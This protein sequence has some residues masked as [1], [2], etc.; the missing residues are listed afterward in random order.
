M[1]LLG[2]TRELKIVMDNWNEV[3]DNWTRKLDYPLYEMNYICGIREIFKDAISQSEWEKKR[4]NR[5]FMDVKRNVFTFFGKRGT[6]KTT[7]MNEFCEILSKLEYDNEKRR[8]LAQSLEK[9]EQSILENKKFKFHVLKPI[10]ASLLEDKENLFELIMANIYLEFQNKMEQSSNYHHEEDYQKDKTSKIMRLFS[11]IFKSYRLINGHRDEDE[12]GN[13]IV[14]KMQLLRGSKHLEE[15]VIGLIEELFKISNDKCDYEYIVIPI[16]DLDLNVKHGYEMLEQLQKYFSYYKIVVLIAIDYEQM[17]LVCEEHF[18]REMQKTTDAYK[19][20]GREHARE[21]AN[22]YMTKIFQFSQRMYMPDMRRLSRKC[23]IIVEGYKRLKV[24]NFIMNKVAQSMFI[25]Y[26]ACGNQSHFSE[27]D[28]VR[29]LVSYNDFLETLNDI[30]YDKLTKCEKLLK[31]GVL[32]RDEANKINRDILEQYD[33]NHERFNLDINVRMAQSIML[34]YQ[35][36]AFDLLNTQPI[37]RRAQLFTC[38]HRA[39]NKI[40]YRNKVSEDYSYGQLL[41]KIYEWGRKDGDNYLEA[42]PFVRGILA[43]FTT[44][45]VREYIYY[46]HKME[47]GVNKYKLRLLDM[48]GNSFGSSWTG[49]A[50]PIVS[51]TINKLPWLQK[52]G[53]QNNL[54]QELTIRIDMNL[55]NER[56]GKP[57]SKRQRECVIRQWMS[58]EEIVETL[59]CIDIFFVHRVGNLYKG[60]EYDFSYDYPTRNTE[61]DSD[62]VSQNTDAVKSESRQKMLNI[63]GAGKD[64]S[65][66]MMAFV[67]KSMNY[68]EEKE[69]LQSNII[70]G[71]TSV[72][73]KCFDCEEDENILKEIRYTVKEEVERKSL[74]SKLNDMKFGYEVAIPFYNLDMTYNVYKRVRKDF[75]HRIIQEKDLI[76]GIIDFYASIETH[77]CNEK[78]IYEES[79]IQFDYPEIYREC[80]YIK[81]IREI[82]SKNNSKVPGRIINALHSITNEMKPEDVT[83]DRSTSR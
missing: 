39:G 47:E 60:M 57:L 78:K 36:N 73:G 43:S 20:D 10:D 22:D 50:F 59:E 75:C 21:L 77:L 23:E 81:A 56:S 32:E 82:A 5:A 17:G 16:D 9:Q 11:D 72:L 65:M 6:G 46:R 64:I 29:G 67:A 49:D 37:G 31:L 51:L 1:K 44:E 26:D 41:E 15:Q 55:L 7:A 24:K 35:K 71:L 58:D 18:R 66:D 53:Y 83:N 3:S 68:E 61:S 33:Q 4:D 62:V 2:N 40:V 69:R 70:E 74:F 13:F 8:W 76:A 14:S 38:A 48:L 25:F 34:P 42:K 30:E 80:P 12:Y 45:L 27:P 63:Y 19:G 52:Y 79:E 28:T 54:L